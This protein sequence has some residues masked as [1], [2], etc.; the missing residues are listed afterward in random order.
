MTWKEIQD[1]I[2]CPYCGESQDTTIEEDPDTIYV[3]CD[4]CDMH[5][6]A[7]LGEWVDI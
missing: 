6:K 2:C 1:W 5:A 7:E 3:F 4:D